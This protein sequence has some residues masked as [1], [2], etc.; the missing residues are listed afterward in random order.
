[1]ESE[2]QVILDLSD[3][4]EDVHFNFDGERFAQNFFVR[5]RGDNAVILNG[6]DGFGET[7][8][9]LQDDGT[10]QLTINPTITLSGV[11]GLFVNSTVKAINLDGSG[12]NDLFVIEDAFNGNTSV[13][14]S[15]AQ[16]LFSFKTVLPTAAEKLTINGGGGDD[17]VRLNSVGSAFKA[18]LAVD[19]EAGTDVIHVPNMVAIPN[20]VSLVADV[21]DV[22]G[23]INTTGGGGL[24]EIASMATP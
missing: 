20:D 3:S 13:T 16:S 22:T 14:L 19:G 9:N 7:T 10:V 8:L 1:M 4:S 15:L 23:G 6:G 5:G 12:L 24:A 11:N 17:R 2:E 18:A 21:I